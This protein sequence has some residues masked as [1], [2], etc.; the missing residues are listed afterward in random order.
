MRSIVP[1]NCLIYLILIL[2]LLFTGWYLTRREFS[3]LMCFLIWVVT[4]ADSRTRAFQQQLA[5]KP[6][7]VESRVRARVNPCGIYGGQSGTGTCFSPSSSVFP[8]QYHSTVVL[9]NHILSG[10]WTMSVS[11]SSSDM[12]SSFVPHTT[13]SYVTSHTKCVYNVIFFTASRKKGLPRK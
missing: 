4:I 13:S 12:V 2:S 10:G 3:D 6:L 11:G 8:Y 5:E 9:D 7:T 1:Q